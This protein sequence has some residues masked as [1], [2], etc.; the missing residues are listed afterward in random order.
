M[1][2]Y[3]RIA[4]FYRPFVPTI[5][6]A[7]VFLLASIGLKLL[8]PWPVGWVFNLLK[9]GTT[10]AELPLI[11]RTVGMGEAL[12]W[13]VFSLIAIQ[14]VWGVFNLFNNYWL[15]EIG[16]RALL[17]LR[18][19]VFARLQYLPLKFHDYRRSGD[20]SFRVAYDTQSIQTFFN[21]GFVTIVSSGLTL[22]GFLAVMLR[23]SVFLTLV[24]VSVI[25]FLLAAIYYFAHRVRRDST[26]VQVRESAVLSRV[27]EALSAIRVV[28]AFGREENEIRRFE[29]EAEGSLS[30]NRRL[31]LT[32]V[33]SSLVVG[34]I[35][36]AGTAAL[37]YFGAQEV[38]QG[39]LDVGR[40]FVFISYLAMFYQPLEQLSY[41]VWAMEGAAAGASRVFEVLDTRDEVPDAPDAGV[42]RPGKGR[43]ELQGVTFAYEKERPV[44]GG[45]T[46]T[47]EP[48][49][50]VALVGGTGAGKTTILSMIPRFYDPDSG[51]VRVD[52]QDLKTVTKKSLRE[53]MSLV[54]QDTL[55]LN[56]S[57][58]DNIT[59]SRPGATQGEVEAA[60]RAAQ[61]DGFIAT[62]PQGYDTEVGERGVRLSGGQRQRIG[63]ARA[64]LRRA[65]ILLLDEPTSALDL[66]TEAELMGALKAL[67]ADP[68]TLIVTH[69]LGT[70]HEVDRI[71]VLEHGRIVESGTG[72][73][74]LGKRG[75]YHQLWNAAKG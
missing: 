19:E 14:L 22:A 24:S 58:R 60:A 66:K 68:T 32:Q 59:Y 71:F 34:L 39:R 72:P 63:I 35:T 55:L 3:R 69:R 36:T 70:V 43:I 20:S 64:F 52:G 45:I 40:L 5:L 8:S 73:E 11:G 51:V 29:G 67:M 30:A 74:L 56:G 10:S 33:V 4:Y 6:L 57:I 17:R 1:N 25:P 42:F 13:A 47:V 65:P 2:L 16:L 62:L 21:R 41:T 26:D 37:I 50:T 28:H 27:T 75:L 12:L 54:L 7:L 23:E 9:E 49:Q 38:Q 53:H 31:T 18:T 61:A 44:L 48:G 46:L 15:I